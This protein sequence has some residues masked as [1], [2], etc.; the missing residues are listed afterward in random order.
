MAEFSGATWGKVK[1]Y[2]EKKFG[3]GAQS[4]G[5]VT[6]GG[7]LPTTRKDGSAL[8]EGDYVLPAPSSSFPFTIGTTTFENKKTTAYW[9]GAAGFVTSTDALQFTNETPVKDKANESVSGTAEYQ[10]DVNK[11]FKAKF[12]DKEDTTNKFNSFDDLPEG[13]LTKYPSGYAVRELNKKNIPSERKVAN[14]T[15]EN[16]ITVQQIIDAIKDVVRTYTNVIIDCDDNTLRNIV[17]SCFKAGEILSSIGTLATEEYKLA[18]AKAIYDFVRSNVQGA[19]KIK[20][21]K[22]TYAEIEAITDA[23]ANDEWFCEAN[24]HFY[25]YTS[26][27]VWM[28]MGG[29]VDLTAYIQKS[30]IVNNLTTNDSQKPL[31]AAQ[32]RV[33]KDLVDTKQDKIEIVEKSNEVAT[34]NPTINFVNRKLNFFMGMTLANIEASPSSPVVNWTS[35]RKE[36]LKLPVPPQNYSYPSKIDISVS[37]PSGQ[38]RCEE[39]RHEFY[40]LDG[41]HYVNPTIGVNVD[42]R[43]TTVVEVGSVDTPVYDK[44]G[45][46]IHIAIW[47]KNVQNHLIVKQDGTP[48][49]NT[50][51]VDISQN[52]TTE[53]PNPKVYV[54]KYTAGQGYTYINKYYTNNDGTGEVTGDFYELIEVPITFNTEY[55]YKCFLMNYQK[56][57]VGENFVV[58]NQG[59]LC[60]Y[61]IVESEASKMAK[62]KPANTVFSDFEGFDGSIT[63]TPIEHN[64]TIDRTIATVEAHTAPDPED[65]TQTIIDY[66]SMY[67]HGSNTYVDMT[68]NKSY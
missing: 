58:D 48:F 26:D 11:E 7:T 4:L 36:I 34:L 60:S 57:M 6:N 68:M 50:Q 43:C 61:K 51:T 18:T 32:G 55:M 37:R 29:G 54:L 22:A 27:G 42:M 41:D 56:R 21:K 38:W 65:P 39:N 35:E 45:N 17:V 14:Y 59:R 33:L 24:S 9:R 47:Q 64:A 30:E 49:V 13:D 40:D 15:L 8:Q 3:K 25:L 23:Q 46:I 31:S 10:S 63:I 19:I 20:G 1:K 16:D 53:Q 28:D 12:S 5:Y 52:P 66:Y 62:A 67:I 44:N 2:I